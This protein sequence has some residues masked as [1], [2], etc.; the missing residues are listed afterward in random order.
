MNRSFVLTPSASR[1]IDN[2]L[3]YVLE[4]SG[5]NRALHVRQ[6]L[7][8]GLSKIALHPEVLG[9]VREDLVNE[10]LRTYAVFS[11]LIFYRPKTKPVEII[12]VIHGARDV[13]TLLGNE[14]L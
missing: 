9:H 3:E 14:P 8:D 13:G 10:S 11:Y 1:D 6:K 7:Y 4:Q 12:R 2:I 5:H